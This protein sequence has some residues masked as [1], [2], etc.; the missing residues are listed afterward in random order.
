MLWLR[1]FK[2]D[3]SCVEITPYRMPDGHI[4]IVPRVI[5]PLPEAADYVVK[6]EKKDAEQGSQRKPTSEG[7]QKVAGA[8]GTGALV[9]V[10]RE[11][12]GFWKEDASA[13]YGGSFIYSLMTSKGWRSLF[14]VNISG[15]RRNTPAGQLDVWIPTKNVAE[16]AGKDQSVVRSALNLEGPQVVADEKIDLVLR[17]SNPDDCKAL[18]NTLRSL[19][20]GPASD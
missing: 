4:V 18:V 13:A 20:G 15:S 11:A 14:G 19:S 6:A 10:C 9:N 12:G 7:L 3:I 17:L 8:K 5:I 16:V 2:V 1:T